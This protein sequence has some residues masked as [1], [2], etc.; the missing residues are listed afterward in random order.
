MQGR[1]VYWVIYFVC[2]KRFLGRLDV[3]Y[4]S[5]LALLGNAR[6]V[7]VIIEATLVLN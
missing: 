1:G 3:T 6:E 2:L 4:L 5:T 7:A